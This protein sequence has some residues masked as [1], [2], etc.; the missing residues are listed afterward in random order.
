M[1]VNQALALLQQ[2]ASKKNKDGMQRFGIDVT[3]ALGVSVTDTRKVAKQIGKNHALAMQLWHTGI[4]EARLLAGMI[5]D[6]EKFTSKM[7]DAWIKEFTSWD[8]VDQ[9]CLNLFHKTSYAYEKVFVYAKKI[10]DFEKRTAFALMACFAWHKNIPEKKII[11]FFPVIKA[12][13]TDERNFVKKAVNWAL[14][15]IGKSSPALNKQAI[16]TAKEILKINNKTAQWIAKDALKE[17]ESNAVQK[18]L[19]K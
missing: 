5:A 17:L 8:L 16:Q 4:H 12:S 3:N 10:R 11:A 2:H 19:K 14:R 6:P 15:Q 1:D 18:R 7:M 9:S 13:A